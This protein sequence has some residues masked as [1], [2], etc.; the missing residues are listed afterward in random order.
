MIPEYPLAR[1][2]LRR[3]RP[4]LRGD[5]ETEDIMAFYRAVAPLLHRPCKVVEVGV[6]WGRSLI[7][8][9]AQLVERGVAGDL[10]YGVDPYLGPG[11]PATGHSSMWYAEALKSLSAHAAAAEMQLIGLLRLPSPHAALLFEDRSIDL[12]LIDGCHAP[13][14][15]RLDLAAW[16]PVVKMGGY[17]AG[18]DYTAEF[19]GVVRAVNDRFG[20][21]VV[22]RGTVWVVQM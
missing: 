18:H 12:V 1:D 21:A 17:L 15:V 8:A 11:D 22:Q 13:E 6:S 19:P 3:W 10:V 20:K 14:A 5:P 4:Q 16:S 9:A 7:Y 2:E